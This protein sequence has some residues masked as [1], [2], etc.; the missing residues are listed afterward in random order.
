MHNKLRYQAKTHAI[1][2]MPSK[3]EIKFFHLLPNFI[4]FFLENKNMLYR[5]KKATI[6]LARG[7]IKPVFKRE[8]I[9]VT[10]TKK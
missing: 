3:E 10:N 2:D 5:K 4:L 9:K 8:W 7:K 1:S 6:A